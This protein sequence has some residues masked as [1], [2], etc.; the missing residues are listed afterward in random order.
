MAP[1]HDDHRGLLKGDLAIAQLS[2]ERSNS[3]GFV[4]ADYMGELIVR[5]SVGSVLVAQNRYY[6]E[7][8]EGFRIVGSV[9]FRFAAEPV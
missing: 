7:I 4:V 6:A 1:S 5:K 3:T 8:T 2:K 9:C